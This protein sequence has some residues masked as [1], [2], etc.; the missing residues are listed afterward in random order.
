MGLVRALTTLLTVMGILILAGF[1]FIGYEIYQRA[2]DPN[3]PRA[4]S[5]DRTP[6]VAAIPGQAIPGEGAALQATP[7]QA[8]PTLPAGSRIGQMMV[9]GTRV[10]YHVTLPDGTEQ[11]HVLDVREGTVTIPVTAPAAAPA[12]GATDAGPGQGGNP[13]AIRPAPATDG[14]PSIG[15]SF[16]AP[17]TAGQ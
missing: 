1:A 17:S 7:F 10:V 2:S 11:I 3:H 14:T 12:S 13:G 6:A 16:R 4:F 9:L 8:T 5:R 15:D